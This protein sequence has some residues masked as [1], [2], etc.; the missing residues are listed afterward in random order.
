MDC[1]TPDKRQRRSDCIASFFNTIA[2]VKKFGFREVGRR[3]RIGKLNGVWRDVLLLERRSPN[4]GV[5]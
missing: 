3:E 4:I 1:K 5:D 2:F